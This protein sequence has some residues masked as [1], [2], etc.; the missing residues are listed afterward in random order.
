MQKNVTPLLHRAQCFH[1]IMKQDRGSHVVKGWVS[2]YG[3]GKT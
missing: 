1:A 2:D 3:E